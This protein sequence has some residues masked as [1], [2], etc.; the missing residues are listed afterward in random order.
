MD[1][2]RQLKAANDKKLADDINDMQARMEAERAAKAAHDQ[3]MMDEVSK[4]QKEAEERC[5]ALKALEDANAALVNEQVGRASRLGRV[6]HWGPLSYLMHPCP[7]LAPI[8]PRLSP[9]GA[10]FNTHLA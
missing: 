4:L 6:Q 7:S 8:A 3:A 2:E 9:L 5:A 10:G 1:I